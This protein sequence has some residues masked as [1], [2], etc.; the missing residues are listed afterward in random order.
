MSFVERAQHCVRYL[1]E[2]PCLASW[3]SGMGHPGVS[4]LVHHYEQQMPWSTNGQHLH[5]PFFAH[6]LQ[7]ELLGQKACVV[8]EFGTVL[9]DF[10]A[11]SVYLLCLGSW[12][13]DHLLL[14]GT[15]SRSWGTKEMEL[16]GKQFFVQS[17]GSGFN[18]VHEC[19][20][21]L[22]VYGAY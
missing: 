7:M 16:K 5:L 6:M 20:F 18:A 11:G 2:T 14:D 9:S 12:G 22:G 19:S 3:W 10:P 15:R 21:S 1:S 4:A 13:F 8:K 17:G